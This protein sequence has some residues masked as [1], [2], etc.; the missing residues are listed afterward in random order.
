[1][2]DLMVSREVDVGTCEFDVNSEFNGRKCEIDVD[3]TVENVNSK[4]IHSILY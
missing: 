1:M 4:V 2:S 3:S